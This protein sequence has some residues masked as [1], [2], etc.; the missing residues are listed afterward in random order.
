[1]AAFRNDRKN[2]SKQILPLLTTEF[3][4]HIINPRDYYNAVQKFRLPLR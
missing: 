4:D 1:K 3:A 2:S